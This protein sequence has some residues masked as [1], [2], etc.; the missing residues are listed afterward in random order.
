MSSSVHLAGWVITSSPL[1]FGMYPSD[2]KLARFLDVIGN[3]EA[4]AINQKW[5]GHPG[6]FVEEVPGPGQ[7]PLN[8]LQLWTKPLGGGGSGAAAN[9]ARGAAAAAKDAAS[10]GK[11]ASSVQEGKEE[12]VV[13]AVFVLNYCA[14]PQNYT[15]QFSKLASGLSVAGAQAT[16][17]VRDVWARTDN[18]TATGSL[19]L[20]LPA[21]D[22]ALLTLT[23][24]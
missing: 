21:Y 5:A 22:S 17:H 2:D 10:Q 24:H 14:E 7:T 12:A 23:M 19:A 18:G 4:I 13:V 3:S 9:S 11:E 16:A 8:K 20:T 6:M 1:I 15:L